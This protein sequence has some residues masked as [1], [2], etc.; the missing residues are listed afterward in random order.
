M[1]PDG[2]SVVQVTETDLRISYHYTA[3]HEEACELYG[4]HEAMHEE[5]PMPYNCIKCEEE[6]APTTNKESTQVR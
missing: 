3:T 4:V 1:H 5:H 2:V 6:N